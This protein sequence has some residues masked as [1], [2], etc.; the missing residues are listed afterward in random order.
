MARALKLVVP[1]AAAG[2]RLDRFLAT[3]EGVG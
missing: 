2:E 3:C 1:P